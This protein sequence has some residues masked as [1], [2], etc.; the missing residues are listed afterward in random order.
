MDNLQPK[1]DLAEGDDALAVAGACGG[2]GDSAEFYKAECVCAVHGHAFGRCH[3]R[4]ALQR[5]E[6]GEPQGTCAVADGEKSGTWRSVIVVSFSHA[7][8]S[9]Q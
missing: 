3:N 6:C 2:Y 9:M 4:I 5:P 7:Y 8:R 1:C